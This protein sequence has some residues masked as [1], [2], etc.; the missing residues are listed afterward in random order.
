MLQTIMFDDF[1]VWEGRCPPEDEPFS[2]NLIKPKPEW[3]SMRHEKTGDSV[4]KVNTYFE[5]ASTGGGCAKFIIENTSP[6]GCDIYEIEL[7]IRP[8]WGTLSE[9]DGDVII[10]GVSLLDTDKDAG[11]VLFPLRL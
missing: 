10:H 3:A 5:K 9:R 1:Q 8:S 7:S 4:L 6:K 2:Q 11:T